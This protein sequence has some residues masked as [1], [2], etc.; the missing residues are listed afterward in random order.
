MEQ[1][2]KW[3]S[4][5]IATWSV[6][7]YDTCLCAEQYTQDGCIPET[8][9]ITSYTGYTLPNTHLANKDD[10]TSEWL[11]SKKAGQVI[12]AR[13]ALT[14]VPGDRKAYRSAAA[15]RRAWLPSALLCL[16]RARRG[17]SGLIPASRVHA[18]GV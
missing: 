1:E 16:Q 9:A 2:Q 4:H 7:M 5:S 17:H 15:I 3:Q 14:R 18:A 6:H 11:L 10:P 8:R 13:A 12:W